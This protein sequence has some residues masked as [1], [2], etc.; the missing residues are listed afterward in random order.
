MTLFLRKLLY[1]LKKINS[2]LQTPYLTVILKVLSLLIFI[3]LIT[4][5]F[6]ATSNDPKFLKILRNTN[7]ANLFVWSYWWPLIIISA[8]F[9][10]RIWCMVCPV[11]LITSIS[12]MIGLKSK[13]PKWILSG[14]AITV[15][16]ILILFIGI[17]GF[18]IHR[19]PSLMA[20]YLL[21]II[22]VSVLVGLI[23]K[24]NTFCRY[25]CPVGYLLG[26]Y[27]RLSFLGWRV[28]DKNVCMSCKDKSCIH[29]NYNYNIDVKSCG[30][31]LYPAEISDNANCILCAGCVKSCA[32]FQSERIKERPNPQLVKI[33]F[34]NDLFKVKP[35]H[36]AEMFFV[37]IVSGFVISEIWSE[38]D[39]T[40]NLLKIIPNYVIEKLSIDIH[41]VNVIINST[42]V[43][44]IYPLILWILPFLISRLFG[45]KLKLKEYLLQYGIAFI[46]IIA[47]AHL[48]KAILKTSSR[49]PY[50][51]HV[52]NDISGKQTAQDILENKII[53][54]QNPDWANTIIS[55]LV[56]IIMI[57]GIYLSI[58]T[59][60]L[61]NKKNNYNTINSKISFS[62][63]AIYGSVFL[64]MLIAWR[65]L[66]F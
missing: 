3:G 7:I 13:R 49:L 16:Y 24:K 47:A 14:W 65:W 33:G 46:P 34:A 50:F 25:F 39:T 37:L 27:S 20:I 30:V 61:I 41:F 31:D 42:I 62:L 9:F 56:S 23:W 51:Q 40:D 45:L 43:F 1:M 35:F 10:G 12:A 36:I 48:D 55:I 21:S 4:I 18:A 11:E 59:V 22:A 17:E 32:N 38:W 53:L 57:L 28:K 15:F 44:I 19:D 6:S 2:I 26:I 29:K 64:F 52:F 66:S 58:K 60:V 54:F 63:S 8:I 5:G